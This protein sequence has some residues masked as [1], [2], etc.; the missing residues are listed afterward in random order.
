MWNNQIVESKTKENNEKQRKRRE[1]N[2]KQF[3]R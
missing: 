3:A 1:K 2:R